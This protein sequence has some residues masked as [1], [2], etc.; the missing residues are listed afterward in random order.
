MGSD[1][2]VCPTDLD[3]GKIK[4]VNLVSVNIHPPSWAEGYDEIV[5]FLWHHPF[6][7][8]LIEKPDVVYQDMLYEF[9]ASCVVGQ[10]KKGHAVIRGTILNGK[11]QGLTQAMQVYL[12]FCRRRQREQ[13]LEEV[14][15]PSTRSESNT[16]SANQESQGTQ[17][18][19]PLNSSKS[20]PSSSSS[21]GE[22]LATTSATLATP[23]TTISKSASK[24]PIVEDLVPLNVYKKK[25]SKRNISAL[26]V[27]KTTIRIKVPQGALEAEERS[28]VDSVT[29]ADKP[30]SPRPSALSQK[31]VDE[32]KGTTTSVLPSKQGEDIETK[33]TSQGHTM[34]K[35]NSPSSASQK[36]DDITKGTPEDPAQIQ[37][38][39]ES[40]HM[41][42]EDD[43]PKDVSIE[44]LSDTALLPQAG[45][46]PTFLHS[47]STLAVNAPSRSQ[48]GVQASILPRD[49]MRDPVGYMAL[50]REVMLAPCATKGTIDGPH[51]VNENQIT[52]SG[53]DSSFDDVL[54]HPSSRDAL[55]EDAS[56]GVDQNQDQQIP[57]GPQSELHVNP[58]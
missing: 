26:G 58:S 46:T 34:S 22:E 6:G 19:E 57:T 27:D 36:V 35:P 1:V 45:Q 51:D 24:R 41:L 39:S 13:A 54:A 20:T 3:T 37:K 47:E 30:N 42:T 40:V 31:S 53:S 17:S 33:T 8:I 28:K 4:I 52:I 48:G 25:R 50:F 44:R 9:W 11:K 21:E 15:S 38:E 7:K 5:A 18:L 49:T 55:M 12:D 16:Q 56:G 2:V 10:T 43:Q 14:A 23:S 32:S 29:Q